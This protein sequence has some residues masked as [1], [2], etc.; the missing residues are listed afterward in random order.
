M[1]VGIVTSLQDPRLRSQRLPYHDTRF[2]NGHQRPV[3]ISG[4]LRWAIWT[5]LHEKVPILG[6]RRELITELCNLEEALVTP[7]RG[8]LALTNGE[9]G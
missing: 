2:R 9:L 3:N 6:A 4:Y 5:S 1:A 8:E 7:L